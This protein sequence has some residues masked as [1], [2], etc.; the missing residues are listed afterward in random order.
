MHQPKRFRSDDDEWWDTFRSLLDDTYKLL[1]RSCIGTMLGPPLTR[2]RRKV[3]TFVEEVEGCAID[4]AKYLR[5]GNRF[6]ANISYPTVFPQQ[7]ESNAHIWQP[8]LD[9]CN[10]NSYRD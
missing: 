3:Q 8:G 4:P 9:L 2:D 6:V 7:F 10:T 1:C 5:T